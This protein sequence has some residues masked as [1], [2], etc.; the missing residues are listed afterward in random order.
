MGRSERETRGGRVMQY[1]HT[2]SNVVALLRA[3]PS[4]PPSA[5]EAKC[6]AVTGARRPIRRWARQIGAVVRARKR[7]E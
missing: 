6:S 4:S 3:P 7:T 1:S 2:R 5:I